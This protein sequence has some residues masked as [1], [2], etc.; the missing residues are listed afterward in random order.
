MLLYAAVVTDP[1]LR[2]RL[3]TPTLFAKWYAVA[4]EVLSDVAWEGTLLEFGLR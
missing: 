4:E 1:T 2:R 3:Q